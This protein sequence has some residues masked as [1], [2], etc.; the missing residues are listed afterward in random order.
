MKGLHFNDVSV[1]IIDGDY[2]IE[3]L[4][5]TGANKMVAISFRGTITFTIT[6]KFAVPVLSNCVPMNILKT[7]I[8]F[9]E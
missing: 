3:V 6:D 4:N 5:S 7:V 9:V 1:M 8:S 2:T